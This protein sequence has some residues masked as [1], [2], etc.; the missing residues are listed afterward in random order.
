MK[1]VMQLILFFALSQTVLSCKDVA[2]SNG[3]IAPFDDGV[4]STETTT[5]STVKSDD[6]R[7]MNVSETPR[8][9]YFYDHDSRSGMTIVRYPFPA[10]WQQPETGEFRYTGPNGVKVYGEGGK[11]FVFSNDQSNV[12]MYQMTG[13]NVRYPLTMNEVIYEFF[14]PVANRVNRKIVKKYPIPQIMEFY[15]NY[16]AMLFKVESYPKQF[17]ATAIEW[18][19]PDGTRWITILNYAIENCPNQ[20]FW[21]YQ[22]GAMGAP[23]KY[24]EKAKQDYLNGMLNR[25]INPQ[26]IKT[27]NQEDQR[28][29]QR[30]NAAHEQRMARFQTQRRPAPTTM[31]TKTA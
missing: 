27:M 16:D 19:D 28:T 23:A 29:I 15:N 18:V 31:G 20:V 26:W 5:K 25:Q 14:V 13:M 8:L 17:E 11:S 12:Q 24:F 21:S 7:S 2:K 10:D 4:A 1:T 9:Q 3:K 30:S 6:D 22:A